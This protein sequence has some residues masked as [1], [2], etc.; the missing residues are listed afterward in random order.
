MPVK[1]LLALVMAKR[2]TN[3][4]Y[5][6]KREAVLPAVGWLVNMYIRRIR[7]IRQV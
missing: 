1:S 2:N 7:Q 4:L 3:L 6:G 5:A